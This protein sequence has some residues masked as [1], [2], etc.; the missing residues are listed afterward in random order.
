MEN[1]TG[2]FPDFIGAVLLGELDTCIQLSEEKKERDRQYDEEWKKIAEEERLKAEAE[3][4]KRAAELAFTKEVLLHGGTIHEPKLI[5]A[6]ADEYGVNIPL[7]TCGW[8][9]NSLERYEITD[10]RISARYKVSGRGKGSSRFFDIIHELRETIS[11][12]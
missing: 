10:G 2:N 11:L 8:I 6:L 9:L 7:R 4:G 3:T 1:E 5:C 12:N